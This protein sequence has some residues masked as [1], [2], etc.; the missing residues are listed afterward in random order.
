MEIIPVIDILRGKVVKAIKGE[1]SKYFPLEDS[2]LVMSSDPLRMVS[3]FKQE[4]NLNKFYIADLDS[5]EQKG[6]NFQTLKALKQLR[7]E[8]MVDIG[9]R[10]KGDLKKKIINTIDYL[11]LGT[12]TLLSLDTVK[13]AIGMK[14]TDKV[15]VSIDLKEGKILKRYREFISPEASLKILYDAGVRNF[16]ILDLAQVGTLEGPSQK[17]NDLMRYFNRADLSIFLGGGITSIKDIIQLERIGIKGVLIGTAFHKGFI[18]KK[19]IQI[20]K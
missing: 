6:N 18:K 10:D 7:I 15:I 13:Y 14:T 17:L 4:L 1:R 3:A 16:I 2:S 19:D 5:I 11:I 8:M 9:I 12:E 20:F